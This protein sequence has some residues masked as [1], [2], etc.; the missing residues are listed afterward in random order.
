[1]NDLDEDIRSNILKF[2]DGTKIFKKLGAAQTVANCKPTLINYFYGH[3]KGKWN[4]RLT[5]AN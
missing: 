3:K 2:A 5:S 1:M 4:S